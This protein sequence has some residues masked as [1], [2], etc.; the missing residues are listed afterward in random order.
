MHEGDV[1]SVDA[2]RQPPE[3]LSRVLT[4]REAAEWLKVRPRQ[5]GVLGVPYL[6]WGHKTKRYV[7]KDVL[8]WLEAQPRVGRRAA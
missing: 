7:A 8:A 6:D 4:P 3:A 2:G 5:L 1:A